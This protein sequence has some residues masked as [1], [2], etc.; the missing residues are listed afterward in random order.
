[1]NDHE[2]S[3][4]NDLALCHELI[5]Q[6]ADAL[7]EAQR[8]IEQLEHSVDLLLVRSTGRAENL[9][10]R[11]N[12]DSSSRRATSPYPR[13]PTF[14]SKPPEG[15]SVPGSVAVAR[16]SPSTCLACLSSLTVR[17]RANLPGVW[18]ASRPLRR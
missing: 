6:Q 13:K 3:L 17:T 4:P 12:C 15:R 5:R 14:L 16:L 11:T 2:A 9:L 8:R 1:M 10:T 7:E 18:R